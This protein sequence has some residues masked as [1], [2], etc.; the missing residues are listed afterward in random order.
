V[1]SRVVL[2]SGSL[3]VSPVLADLGPLYTGRDRQEVFII[4]V[5]ELL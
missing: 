4:I 1:V 3:T 2:G 5:G